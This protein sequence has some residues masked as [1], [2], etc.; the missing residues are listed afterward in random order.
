MEVLTLEKL[1]SAVGKLLSEVAE[2]KTAIFERSNQ[3]SQ[4]KWMDLDE[5]LS[6]D[7]EKRTKA[8]FYSYTRNPGSGFPFHKRGKRILVLKSEFDKWL[9][10]GRSMASSNIS[11][12]VDNLLSK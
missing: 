7:P 5:L 10:E 3:P 12:T 4:D 11:S 2:I 9:K 1:P 6:Y 8:T